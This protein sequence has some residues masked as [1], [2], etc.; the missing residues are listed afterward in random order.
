MGSAPLAGPS[1][2][3]LPNI[4]SLASSMSQFSTLVSLLSAAGLVGALSSGEL[5]VFEPTNDAFAKL[6]AALV[7]FLTQPENKQTLVRL[8]CEHVHDR[9]AGERGGPVLL[10][11]QTDNVVCRRRCSSTMCSG[12]RC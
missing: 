2:D 3:S 4:P 8:C 6:P 10:C 1:S 5:T 7:T 12:Q 11:K 9:S